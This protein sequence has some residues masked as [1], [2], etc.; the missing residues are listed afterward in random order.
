MASRALGAR[1]PAEGGPPDYLGE[2]R[3]TCLKPRLRC[4]A[5]GADMTILCRCGKVPGV[6][7]GN[8]AC[9]LHVKAHCNPR[10]EEG[11]RRA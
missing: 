6:T 3:N 1:R 11:I 7:P 4:A 9:V 2:G 10:H 8:A 5:N